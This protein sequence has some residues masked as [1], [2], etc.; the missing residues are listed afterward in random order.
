MG[1]AEP[2]TGAEEYIKY[3]HKFKLVS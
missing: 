2:T 3:S 1:D